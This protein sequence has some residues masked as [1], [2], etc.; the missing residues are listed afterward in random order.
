MP[1]RVILIILLCSCVIDGLAQTKKAKPK[2]TDV[3]FTVNNKSIHSEE[4]IYLYKKN[5]QTKPDEYSKEDILSYLDLFI[6]FKLKVEEARHRGMDTTSAFLNEYNSYRNELLKPYLPDNK[7]IDSLTAQTYERLKQEVRASH[8]LIGLKPESTPADTLAAFNKIMD[9]KKRVQAGEDFAALAAT[10]SE[11]PSA[12][13]NKGDLGYFTALQ[14]VYSF[15]TAA[16][17]TQIGEMSAP[18]RTQFGYHLIKVIDK[19][20]ARGEVEVSHIMIRAGNGKDNAATKNTIFNIYDQLNAGASWDELC[21]QYS[22]DLSSKENNGRLRPFGVGAMASVPQFEQVAFSLQEAGEISDPFETA[23]GWH[24]IRLERKIPLPPFDQIKSQLRSRVAKDERVQISRN[25]W[26]E[27]LKKEFR[28]VENEKTKSAVIASADSSLMKASWKPHSLAGIDAEILF[29]LKGSGYSVKSFTDFVLKNQRNASESP[30]VI[31][32]RLYDQYVDQSLMKLLEQKISNDNP[33]FKM[34][35]NEYYEGILLFEIMEKEVWNKAADDSI[36]Q[37]KY[38]NQHRSNYKAGER[39]EATFYSSAD[40]A[41][42]KPLSQLITNDDSLSTVKYIEEKKLREESGIYEKGNK[43]ILDKV[44]WA[45]GVYFTENSGMYYLA[46][47]RRILPPGE[48]TFEEARASV[49][50]DYQQELENNWISLLRKKYPV[51]V[52]EK[53]KAY[54]LD[55]LQ[56]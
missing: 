34:L 13:V 20:P 32:N 12:R 27:K 16:F 47:I 10:Y 23:F 36:G 4:F 42:R 15:E 33:E 3:L 46:Q 35:S 11:D 9:L 50:A 25:A 54:V 8:I 28:F 2:K 49:V 40:S 21:R 43:N 24:I 53:A 14:M 31:M 38:F 29:T 52:N 18:V 48:M 5:H 39:V 41:F 44:T 55:K 30:D 19:R 37:V 56:K 17:E 7:I 22:E 6:N 26:Q 51:K 1:G 45:P